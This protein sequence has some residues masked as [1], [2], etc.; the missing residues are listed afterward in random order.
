MAVAMDRDG[1]LGMFRAIEVLGAMRTLIERHFGVWIEDP[2][3]V[4]VIVAGMAANA[5]GD[6]LKIPYPIKL[7][8]EGSVCIEHRYKHRSLITG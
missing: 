4:S 5:A 2:A 3:I 8:A 6:H 1:L 7:D